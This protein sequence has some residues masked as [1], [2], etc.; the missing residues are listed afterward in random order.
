M[1]T[2][3]CLQFDLT[4]KRETVAL[5]ASREVKTMAKLLNRMMR[6]GL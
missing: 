4:I 2:N 3:P 1:K 6:K 5:R